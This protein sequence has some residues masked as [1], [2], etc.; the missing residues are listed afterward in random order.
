MFPGLQSMSKHGFGQETYGS[1]YMGGKN[2]ESS[3]TSPI[4]RKVCGNTLSGIRPFN[5]S[6]KRS[7]M[8]HNT[9][10]KENEPHQHI[11]QTSLLRKHIDVPKRS[12]LDVSSK[13]LG[14]TPSVNTS[15]AHST[16][17]HVPTPAFSQAMK[18][19]ELDL[20]AKQPYQSITLKSS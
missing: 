1:S 11:E 10:Q 14:P 2:F 4:Q 6:G 15:H 16:F 19:P 12:A 9:H 8:V 17:G 13:K 7:P 20:S 18:S 3:F 5:L